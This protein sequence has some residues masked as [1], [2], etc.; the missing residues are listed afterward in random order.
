MWPTDEFIVSEDGEVIR[1]FN[2]YPMRGLPKLFKNLVEESVRLAIDEEPASVAPFANEFLEYVAPV[3]VSGRNASERIESVASSTHPFVK[4]L[5]E[6]GTNRNSWLHRDTVPQKMEGASP[7]NQYRQTTP[8]AYIKAGE[9]TGQPPLKL[10]QLAETLTGGAIRQVLPDKPMPGQEASSWAERALFRRF[11]SL[12]FTED[13]AAIE[14]FKESK[15][16]EVDARLDADRAAHEEWQAIR[17]LP[18]GEQIRR[19]VALRAKDPKAAEYLQRIEKEERLGFT[20]EDRR[21]RQLGVE[22]QERARYISEKMRDM[23]E[24]E[25]NAYVA[26]LAKKGLLGRKAEVLKQAYRLRVLGK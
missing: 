21:I 9:V 15:A 16:R 10:K 18:Q 12:P 26:D 17:G 1:V 20:D 24:Q 6:Y 5:W 13:E 25:R 3:S 11:K 4:G 23:D 22:S 19:M 8:D 14:T 7:E 2:K